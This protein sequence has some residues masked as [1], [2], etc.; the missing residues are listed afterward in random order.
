MDVGF[1]NNVMGFK[2]FQNVV[3]FICLFNAHIMNFVIINRKCILV[4]NSICVAFSLL[5]FIS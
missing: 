2:S 4:Y 3:N 5:F 1:Y